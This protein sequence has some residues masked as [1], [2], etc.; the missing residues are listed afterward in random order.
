MGWYQEGSIVD[1]FRGG[2]AETGLGSG[3]DNFINGIISDWRK[4]AIKEDVAQ[5]GGSTDAFGD[6][7]SGTNILFGITDEERIKGQAALLN[8]TYGTQADKYDFSL[9]NADGTN[10]SKQEIEDFLSGRK[11]VQKMLDSSGYSAEELGFNVNTGS[12]SQLG[13]LIR[14]AKEK[15]AADLR[16][17][18]IELAQGKLELAEQTAERD[19]SFKNHQLRVQQIEAENQRRQRNHE[20]QLQRE[21]NRAKGEMQMQIAMME[22]GDRR[23][24][25]E[26]RREDRLALQRQQSIA[27]LIKG[28]TQMGAG[29]AI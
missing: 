13:S 7:K 10:K 11:S 22:Q 27:Q 1:A 26:A 14:T 21:E 4:S 15:Q 19:S 12:A 8:T 5:G 16:K 2:E 23:A 9:T 17:P 29:F 18:E 28:L 6:V 24:D 20:L 25:R 3:V